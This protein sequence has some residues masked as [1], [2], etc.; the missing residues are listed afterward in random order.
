MIE[1]MAGL[2]RSKPD[3]LTK[4]EQYKVLPIVHSI[5]FT[6]TVS[7]IKK[8]INYETKKYEVYSYI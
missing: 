2:F 1:G 8:E 4:G 3:L 7:T 5:A 6:P